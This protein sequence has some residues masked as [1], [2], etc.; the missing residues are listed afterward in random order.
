MSWLV[1][2]PRGAQRHGDELR[3]RCLS[4]DHEDANPSAAYNVI[5]KA[6]KCQGCGIS[7]GLI[8]GDHPIALLTRV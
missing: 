2:R 3:Y 6:H 4:D 1:S 8:V 7:G 5:K